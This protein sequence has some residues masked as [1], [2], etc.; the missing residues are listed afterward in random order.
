M[1]PH[2]GVGGCTPK[3]RNEMAASPRRTARTAAGHHDDG[4]RDV[5]QHVAEKQARPA[6]AERRRGMHVVA[7]FHRQHLAPHD[8]RVD[9][10][11]RRRQAQDDVAQAQPTMALMGD[12]SRMTERRAARRPA[13]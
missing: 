9:D 6:D 12:A 7:L 13:A 10:P 4:R 5:G 11:A 2:A 1:L 8:A 3:P